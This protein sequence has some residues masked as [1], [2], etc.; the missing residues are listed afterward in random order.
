MNL[1]DLFHKNN[2][3]EDIEVLP[4][5]AEPVYTPEQYQQRLDLAGKQ[6]ELSL[7]A[8]NTT[9]GTIRN[10]HEA[11]LNYKLTVKGMEKDWKMFLKKSDDD[12]EKFKS[13]IP[14][15][16]KTLDSQTSNLNMLYTKLLEMDLSDPSADKVLDDIRHL[17]DIISKLQSEL[18]AKF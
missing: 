14:V 7:A 6:L 4:A 5:N 1:L 13:M 10:I 15:L 11:T 17:S 18:I 8:V 12:M 16:M 9:V 2:S 3:S